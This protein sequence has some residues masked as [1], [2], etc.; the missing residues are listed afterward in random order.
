MQKEKLRKSQCLIFHTGVPTRDVPQ[1]DTHTHVQTHTPIKNTGDCC[2]H[3]MFLSRHIRPRKEA[4]NRKRVNVLHLLQ[5][6]LPP[7]PLCGKRV[8]IVTRNEKQRFTRVQEVESVNQEMVVFFFFFLRPCNFFWMVSGMTSGR[9]GRGCKLP[10]GGVMNAVRCENT[11]PPAENKCH[12]VMLMKGWAE[13]DDIAAA[14]AVNDGFDRFRRCDFG[15]GE[16]EVAIYH[17]KHKK[18]QT[19]LGSSKAKLYS[20]KTT[21]NWSTSRTGTEIVQMVCFRYTSESRYSYSTNFFVS[22]SRNI[23]GWWVEV[24]LTILIFRPFGHS[25]SSTRK[26][27]SCGTN[28]AWLLLSPCH[29]IHWSLEVNIDSNIDYLTL[30]L[31]PPTETNNM[32]QNVH[33]YLISLLTF[34]PVKTFSP[35]LSN[36]TLSRNDQ[37]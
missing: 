24:I 36:S 6:E 33:I 1:T 26:T 19:P 9:G 17:S 20:N 21:L 14:A 16:K 34:W 18:C 4:V 27:F 13:V 5:L 31:R 28:P 7:S 35:L 2:I 29:E 12:G 11:F 23:W 22:S 10:G 25:T 15:N 37:F 32:I 8:K 30:C 3:P